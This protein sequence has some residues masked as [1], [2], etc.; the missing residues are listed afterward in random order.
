MA[1]P[2][3][4]ALSHRLSLVEE[5]QKGAVFWRGGDTE[6]GKPIRLVSRG[7]LGALVIRD[8]S[9]GATK[10]SWEALGLKELLGVR[11]AVL[12]QTDKKRA[13]NNANI[14]HGQEIMHGKRK[15]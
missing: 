12:I 7:L 15:H 3:R 9:N 6:E 4:A 13:T 5:T 11:G 10:W 2:H 1:Q 14:T 8:R